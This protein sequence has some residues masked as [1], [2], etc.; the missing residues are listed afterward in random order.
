[1]FENQEVSSESVTISFKCSHGNAF[2]SLP[3]L[4]P[5]LS[6]EEITKGFL[7]MCNSLHGEEARTHLFHFQS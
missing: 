1:M 3:I 6:K 5:H 7:N 2:L 4:H